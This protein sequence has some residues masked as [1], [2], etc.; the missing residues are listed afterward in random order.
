[1]L[2]CS[3]TTS[4]APAAT[5]AALLR[6][7]ALTALEAEEMYLERCMPDVLRLLASPIPNEE[8]ANHPLMLLMRVHGSRG[9]EEA[10]D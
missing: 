8:L 10:V 7:E 2:S 4:V 3:G 9:W 1:M 6:G 5:S